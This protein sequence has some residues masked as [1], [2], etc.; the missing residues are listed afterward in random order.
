MTHLSRPCETAGPHAVQQLSFLSLP[1]Q[2]CSQLQSKASTTSLSLLWVR[3]TN[4]RALESVFI[5]TEHALLPHGV[6][7]RTRGCPRPTGRLYFWRRMT[8]CVWSSGQTPGCTTMKTISPHSPATCS[9]PCEPVG[10]DSPSQYVSKSLKAR[11]CLE[12][13]LPMHLQSRISCSRSITLIAKQ[14]IDLSI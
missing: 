4:P 13:I 9:S 10:W 3:A 8:R 14:K 5:E 12:Q 2:V 1:P 11:T 7:S 6:G